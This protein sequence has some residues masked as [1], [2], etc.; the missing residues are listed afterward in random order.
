MHK[1]YL[2]LIFILA[3]PLLGENMWETHGHNY[4]YHSYGSPDDEKVIFPVV[5]DI[6]SANDLVLIWQKIFGF[7]GGNPIYSILEESLESGFNTALVRSEL[8]D[9]W[10]PDQPGAAGDKFFPLAGAVRDIG[11][12][13]MVGGLKTDLNEQEHN[14]SVIDYLKLYISLTAGTYPGDLIGFFAFDEPDVKYL[15]NPDQAVEWIEFVSYWNEV[16]R[17][18]L[19]LPVLCYFA[20]YAYT[21]PEGQ[22]DYYRDTTT[23][24]NR[25]ARFTDMVGIDMYP[26]KNNFR[27][28]DLLHTSQEEPI[29]VAAT[30]IVQTNQLQIQSL[31]SRDELIRVFAQ[32]DSSLISVE[33]IHWDGIDLSLQTHWTAPLSFLPDGMASSDFRAGYAV[34]EASGYVN[35]GLVFWKHSQPVDEA[36]VLVSSGSV[37]TL[38][39]LPEFPGSTNLT[40]LFFCVG[41]TD[42]WSDIQEV[43]GIIGRGR[44]AILAGLEDENGDQYLMFFT[45]AGGESTVI[46]AVFSSPVQLNFHP[47]AAVWGTFWGTWYEFG[48][49]QTAARNGFIVLDENGD[50]ITLHQLCRNYWKL[51]PVQGSI[52]F[53]DLFGSSE[54]P[55]IIR[56]CRVDGNYPPFFA[57]HD[58]LA[59]WFADQ[60]RIVTASSNF[61]GGPFTQYDSI[62]VQGLPGEVTGFDLLR[63]DRRYFD[64][65]LFT[66]S[67]GDVYI[68]T[69]SMET[70]NSN[71]IINV[72]LVNYCQGDTVITGIR[73]MHTRD[74]IRSVILPTGDGYYIPQ[75]EIYSDIVDQRR[76]QW[77]PEAHQVGMDIGVQQTARDNTLF[78][79]VQSYGRHG[80]ALPTY[81]A[82]PD[83][84]LYLVTVPLVAGARGLV[85]YAL[86]MSMMSGNGGDDGV[87]RAP[88]LLQNW[89]PSR[90]TENVD[91][92]GVVHN[93]V[94]SLTGNGAN[95]TDY[96]SAL[97]DTTWSVM[98]HNAVFNRSEADTLLN[99]IALENSTSDTI[100]VIAVNE[101]TSQTP[102]DPG[103][104]FADL[105]SSFGMVSS[106]GFTPG[107]IYPV[108]G[109]MLELDYSAM[110]G[111]TASL[112]TLASGS[113]QQGSG[114]YLSTATS[115]LGITSINFSLPLQET[116]ELVLY[117]L[118]G[119]KI[120]TLWRGAGNGFLTSA[121]V[122]KGE[123]PA[124]LYFVTLTGE[125]TISTGK[126]LLW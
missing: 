60:E 8:T 31:N 16:C 28:T 29:F 52:Q 2:L 59:G 80:F 35:S 20:K 121:D 53:H 98:D 37:P 77:Y 3:V 104:V 101:S 41:Q 124:G 68:G 56:V 27:R 85:F 94:A 19:N 45:A 30:D 61:S 70:G 88:F 23:V 123:F 113:E 62:T 119:R 92:V 109:S 43:S 26:V 38:C 126:C 76:F 5:W 79:V 97:V 32:G 34:H 55:D 13:L 74:A 122:E 44:L 125:N 63:N 12:H 15:E 65:P 46:E 108:S 86:D 9:K 7:S 71:G 48:T 110:D 39:E 57:G 10:F 54:M 118:A 17:E 66:V 90:D 91:M 115:S 117:D 47:V 40:P 78:A 111:V 11:L 25:M 103:I 120:T 1:K 58:Q 22:M 89:G 84:M 69:E 51:Y 81:C 67:G 105:P 96:L 64:R 36:V 49:T 73:A 114:W 112:I 24:L 99:F 4:S 14:Q 87:S 107:L 116:G 42:Y 50:Y 75:C 95:E 21:T 106:E 100:L 102:F 33:N 72:E 82:S 6:R 83:T 93:A 18:E